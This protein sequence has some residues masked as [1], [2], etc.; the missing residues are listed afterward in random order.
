MPESPQKTVRRAI[1]EMESLAGEIKTLLDSSAGGMTQNVRDRLGRELMQLT[2]R[3]ADIRR[4]L[5]PGRQREIALSLGKP[6]A[7]ARF[8]AFSLINR[9]R[10]RLSDVEDDRVFG[11]GVYAVYYDGASVPAYEP[12]SGTETPIYLGKAV[13]EDPTAETVESQGPVLWNRLRQHAKSI[14]LGGLDP[15]EFTTRHAVIQSGMEGAV[16]DFLIRLFKPIWNKETKI[17]HGIGKHGDRATTRGNRRSPWDTMHPGRLW[18]DATA[19]DQRT[20][21]EIVAAIGHHLRENPPVPTREQLIDLLTL[22]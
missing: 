8:Y 19:E 20:R 21:E 22:E 10:V 16:E 1:G 5:D 9:P 13:P 12:L 7:I 14:Q 11:S 6:D 2:E 4:Q 18:A 3:L 17:C 15:A